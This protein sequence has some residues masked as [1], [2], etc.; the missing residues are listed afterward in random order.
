MV[1]TF[2]LFCALDLRAATGFSKF[3]YKWTS[4]YRDLTIVWVRPSITVNCISGFIVIKMSNTHSC[5]PTWPVSI[6][7]SPWL[8]LSCSL[9]CSHTVWVLCSVLHEGRA[10]PPIC[11]CAHN[12][13]WQVKW[14]TYP[15]GL[16]I[17]ESRTYRHLRLSCV[18]HLGSEGH[19]VSVVR[20]EIRSGKSG[21]VGV[22][23]KI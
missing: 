20:L 17:Q 15:L 9:D 13:R 14:L 4:T 11:C 6:W 19:G 16:L 22:G 7:I 23:D 10:K 18:W 3:Y 5:I 2:L 21:N 12:L 8:S 1:Y